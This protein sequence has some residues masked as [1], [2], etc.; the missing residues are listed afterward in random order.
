[1]IREGVFPDRIHNFAHNNEWLVRN[2]QF[3]G[4]VH[5]AVTLARNIIDLPRHPK[6]YSFPGGKSAHY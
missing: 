1:M 4:R 3:L 5:D 6:Y 2:L